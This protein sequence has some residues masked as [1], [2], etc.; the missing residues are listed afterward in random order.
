[1]ISGLFGSILRGRAAVIASVAVAA[2]T[3]SAHADPIIVNGSFSTTTNGYGEIGD[4]ANTNVTGWT[5]NGYNFVFN[6]SNATTGVNGSAGS[7]ALWT[8]GNGS[9]NGFTASPNGG[10]FLALDGAFEVGAVS[11]NVTGLTVGDQETI[12]FYYAG[13]QQDGFTGATTEGLTVSFGNDSDPL[14]TLDNVSHG[15]TGWQEASVTFT[16]SSTSEVLSFLANGTP[17]GEPPMTLLDGVSISQSPVPEPGTLTLLGTG[18][19]GL[20]G[21][22]R[23][24]FL[25]A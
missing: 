6:T 19:L 21:M 8:P 23:R 3:L 25:K 16:A 2:F 13:A 20:G 14:T 12:T 7:V 11:Q 1:M 5:T 17:N 15:F 22:V 10:N 4:N 24:R 9:N 18:I